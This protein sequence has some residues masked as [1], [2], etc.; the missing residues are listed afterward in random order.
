MARPPSPAAGARAMNNPVI[1]VRVRTAK[2]ARGGGGRQPGDPNKHVSPPPYH[3]SPRKVPWEPDRRRSAYSGFPVRLFPRRSAYCRDAPNSTGCPA[4][5]NG[6]RSSPE[7][8]CLSILAGPGAAGARR[9]AAVLRRTH[10]QPRNSFSAKRLGTDCQRVVCHKPLG[11]KELLQESS[12]QAQCWPWPRGR[13]P[14][15]HHPQGHPP[16]YILDGLS[17]RRL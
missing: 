15:R 16:K 17:L 5:V 10:T 3:A 7:G 4:P 11:P 8:V 6:R 13:L 2:P 1:R 9:W 14:H 12:W